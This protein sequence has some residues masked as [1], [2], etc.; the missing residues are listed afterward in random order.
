[1]AVRPFVVAPKDYAPV[2]NIVGEHVLVPLRQG[3][4]RND[5]DDVTAWCLEDVHRLGPGS[6]AGESRLGKARRSWRPPWTE[7]GRVIVL[8]ATASRLPASRAS[9][10]GAR[11]RPIVTAAVAR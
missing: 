5:L 11:R 1:M 6:G 8:M 3:R 7:S 9:L 2:L 4:R 10:T